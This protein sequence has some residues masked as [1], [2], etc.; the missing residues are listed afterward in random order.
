M[1]LKI[2]GVVLVAVVAF[3][4]IGQVLQLIVPALV[5]GALVIAGGVGYTAIKRRNRRELG[6]EPLVQRRL[7]VVPQVRVT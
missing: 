3:W 7:G 5:I 6:P 4:L 2:L 1:V